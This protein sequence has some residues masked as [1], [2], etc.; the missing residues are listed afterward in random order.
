MDDGY[1]QGKRKISRNN[2]IPSTLDESK[3]EDMLTGDMTKAVNIW[4]LG[5]T[6][7]MF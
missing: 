6:I 4:M 2:S 1:T 3:G 7:V 5:S